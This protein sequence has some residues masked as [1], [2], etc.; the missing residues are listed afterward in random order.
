[1]AEAAFADGFVGRWDLTIL[2]ADQKPLPSWL[3]L[4]RD[5][6][7]W[8]ATFVGRWGNAR[9]LPTVAVQR[10]Q[11]RFVSPKQEEDSTNDLVFEGTLVDG[12]MTGS[13]QG[14]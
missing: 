5:E 3:E 8:R 7:T 4:K 11:I 1:M 10:D 12:T 6:R 14:P 13:A 9:P 2:D